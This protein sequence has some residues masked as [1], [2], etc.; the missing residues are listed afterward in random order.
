M[1]KRWLRSA[2]NRIFFPAYAKILKIQL[3]NQK[4]ELEQTRFLLRLAR[5]SAQNWKWL[6]RANWENQRLLKNMSI[7]MQGEDWRYY[8]DA[9]DLEYRPQEGELP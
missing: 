2:W 6:Y 4:R 9:F 5:E 7:Y 8:N 1:L 3:E